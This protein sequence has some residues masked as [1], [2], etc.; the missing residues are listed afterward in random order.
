MKCDVFK[1]EINYIK[2]VEHKRIIEN[3]LNNL[4]DYFYE[5]P[6]SSTGK[7]H[8]SFS[9]GNGG[10]VR[11]T[12]VA[13]KIAKVLLDNDTIGTHSF[14]DNDKDLIIMALLLHDGFKSGVIKEKYTRFD[15]PILASNYVLECKDLKEN[16]KKLIADMISCHMG[17][18]NT[19]DYSDITLP[20]PNNKYQRFVHMC[21]FLS[22]KKFLDVKFIDNEIDE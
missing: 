5:I 20:L 1:T 18:W 21:D 13:V 6:A 10:L 3:L 8:P 9:L 15:H 2:D 17:E 4:P 14:N 11:H 12:K 19:S 16:E 22:S 7:Y